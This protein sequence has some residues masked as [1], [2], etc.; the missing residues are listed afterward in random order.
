MA[1]W[2]KA[3]KRELPR[4]AQ[5]REAFGRTDVALLGVPVDEDGPEA[6]SL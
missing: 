5:L 6:D 2:C 4:V 3:C 1:T